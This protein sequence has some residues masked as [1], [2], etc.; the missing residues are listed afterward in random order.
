M[1]RQRIIKDLPPI[2]EA[3]L[4]LSGVKPGHSRQKA[5]IEALRKC[6]LKLQRVDPRPF[7]SMREVADH[8]SAPLRTVAL[9]YEALDLEGHLHRIRGSQTMLAGRKNLSR[10]PVSAVVGLPIWLTSMIISPFECALQIEL[11]EI[12][13]SRGFVADSIFYRTGEECEPDFAS[14]LLRHNLDIL[15]WQAPHPL[16][17]H[18]L[19]SL[20]ERGVRLILLQSV[21]SPLSI[22]ARNYFFDWQTAYREMAGHWEAG[23]IRRIFIPEPAHLLSR[24]ALR[25]MIPVLE[26]HPF[27]IRIFEPTAKA[28]ALEFPD[29]K[30]SPPSEGTDV[31]AFM[32]LQ[33]TD[34]L[35]NGHPDLIEQISRR[36]RLA[37]CRGPVRVPRLSTKRIH[38]DVVQLDPSLVAGAVVEDLCDLKQKQEGTRR[39]FQAQFHSQIIMKS[40]LDQIQQ[41]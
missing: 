37:F 35:C 3:F 38:V 31:L 32:D 41:E 34:T 30:A 4:S 1:A 12:L 5:L 25:N 16:S 26:Q 40:T 33:I 15:I 2:Q 7:Y 21:E 8:F 28:L 10:R 27:E 11:D 18:V 6:A 20:R 36:S 23:G 22:P 24:R 19:M 13:R 14:R 39:T 29:R 9:A 17:S